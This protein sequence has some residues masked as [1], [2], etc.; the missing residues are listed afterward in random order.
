MSETEHVNSHTN[1]TI[2][3]LP[4]RI[5]AAFV[6]GLI[7]TVIL[8]VVIAPF[9]KNLL[10]SVLN[11]NVTSYIQNFVA[12][13]AICVFGFLAYQTF[14]VYFK[15]ATVGKLIFKIKVVNLFTAE[16]PSLTE[17]FL[18]SFIWMVSVIPFA[19]PFL[20][21][22][23]NTQR[24]ALHDRINDTII[25]STG[26]HV[27]RAP[28]R[29][30][31]IV[32]RSFYSFF[33]FMFL[34]IVL[35]NIINIRQEY[36][37][38][39]DFL[40]SFTESSFVCEDVS[41]AQNEWPKDN[42][43]RESRLVVALTLFATDQIDED[44][45]DVEARRA[46]YFN[47]DLHL[48]YLAKAFSTSNEPGLSDHYLKKVCDIDE[49]SDACSL[50][51]I[52]IL[53]TEKNWDEASGIFKNLEASADPIIKIWAVKHF[54]KNKNY[55]EELKAVDSLW[56]NPV[57]KGYIGTHRTIALWGL[58]RN[59]E[60]RQAFLGTYDSVAS[61]QKETLSAWMCDVEVE[62]SC[63]QDHSTS[64]QIF[65]KHLDREEF[66][67]VSTALTYIKTLSCKPEFN[68]ALSGLTYKTQDT[69]LRTYIRALYEKSNKNRNTARTMFK[70][71]LL[72]IDDDPQFDYEVR[73]Q[74]I[75]L[76][77]T[78]SDVTV[79]FNEWKENESRNWYWIR[80]G[81]RISDKYFELKKYKK[82]AEIGDILVNID[83]DSP[84]LKQKLLVAY[85]NLGQTEKLY[86]IVNSMK[87]HSDR[88]IASKNEWEDIYS[89]YSRGTE[90]FKQGSK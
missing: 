3:T 60:A 82:V 89:K 80:L 45:L 2:A 62:E 24:R 6:D 7:L 21:I 27:G 69:N 87:P 29:R 88:T 66:P 57:L 52:I 35:I 70:K 74:L 61:D 90:R 8:G 67:I 37:S 17:S 28:T 25:V 40:G 43:R 76:S 48:A 10:Y 42:G 56:P 11:E 64:C 23:S 77:N 1:L 63:S 33:L 47:E 19:L 13:V 30:E 36:T 54:E 32:V 14:M 41:D 20:E 73:R 83:P 86:Q 16:T 65:L 49:D 12:I 46:F 38:M 71:L 51:K 39:N 58:H 85:F 5:A 84:S 26:K 15:G 78:E 18:R 68:K 59:D 34:S 4:D 50:T 31:K 75:D 22:F 81:H 44:C 9:R 55:Y 72:D 79:F 53:W